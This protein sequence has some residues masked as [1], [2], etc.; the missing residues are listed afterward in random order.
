MDLV[1]S[2]PG[3]A[4][5]VRS[6]SPVPPRLLTYE[7]WV[8]F[9]VSLGASGVRALLNLLGDL[10][11]GAP[12]S[13]QTAVLNASRA[14]GRPTY[15]L[16]LQLAALGLGLAPVALVGYL[17][18]R[19]G[20]SRHT[21]GFDARRPRLDVVRGCLLAAA[22]GGAGLCLY[23]IAHALGI[24]L[25]VVAEDLPEVWWR[26][27]VLVLSAAQNAVLEEVLVAG[28]LLHRLSQLGWRD[29]PALAVSSVLR[30]SYHLYQGFGGFLGNVAMGL[31]F[32][33]L[34]QR[35]G[36]VGPLVVAHTLMDVVAFV[37]YALFAGHV[38]WL[39]TPG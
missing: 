37:G 23:L 27:P 1:A 26:I 25:T 2:V 17:L 30:G 36:R 9:A 7:I 34:Y 22:V 6:A 35:W 12:L 8:V 13:S 14:P 16:V 29:G 11:R 38:S 19:S 18:L 20:E 21:I 28:Y 5:T 24:N 39:P 31:I 32:G 3:A 15:D 33:R 10:T 4:S